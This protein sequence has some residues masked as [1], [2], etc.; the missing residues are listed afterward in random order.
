MSHTSS[1]PRLQ[2]RAFVPGDFETYARY[3]RQPAVYRYLY[4][5]APQEPAVLQAQFVRDALPQRLAQDG[6]TRRYAVVRSSDGCLLGE[7]LLKLA[8]AAAR[9]AELGYIFDPAH[10]GQGYATEAVA[11]TLA[12]GFGPL[13]FHRIFARLDAANQGSVGVVERLGMRREAHL[14]E[15]DQFNGQWGDEYIYALLAR[16]WHSRAG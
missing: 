1:V 11:L 16:E 8:S 13:G 14:I 6:D 12:Q 7:T 15:N 4:T 10:G 3:H 5:E 9:Q 2:L